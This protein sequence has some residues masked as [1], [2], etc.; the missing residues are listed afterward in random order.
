MK[1]RSFILIISALVIIACKK[2]KEETPPIIDDGDTQFATS[3][4]GMVAAAQPLA[5]EAGLK[6]LEVGGNAADAAL[7]TA[8]VI[9][10]VEPTMNG[11]GGRNLILVRKKDGTF[12]GY[13]GMTEIPSSYA[14]PEI[15][16]KSGHQTIA[17]PGVVAALM[18]LHREH[19]SLPLKDIMAASIEHAAN[20]FEILTGEAIRHEIAYED[21]M[22]DPG[23]RSQMLKQDSILYKA[24][25]ILKQE[26]LGQTLQRIADTGGED[27][28]TGLTA[29]Q[30]VLHLGVGFW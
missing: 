17:T 28:Y 30:I 11:I 19:G 5:T 15:P 13:N 2:K 27:F 18:R 16:V 4:S 14:P 23:F 20:G 1:V 10:V 22:K 25:D 8:F 9:A 6:I 26:D 29:K 12:Q 7:A 21:M 24:G 3:Q